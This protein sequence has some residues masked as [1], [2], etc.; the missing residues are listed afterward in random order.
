M[1]NF[2]Q[3]QN[4][5]RLETVGLIGVALCQGPGLVYPGNKRVAERRRQYYFNNKHNTLSP[6]QVY[7][8][9]HQ[10]AVDNEWDWVVYCHDDLTIHEPKWTYNLRHLIDL[11]DTVAVGLGGATG[12]GHPNL[13]K[14][15]YRMDLM[16]RSNYMSNQTDAETHGKR[17]NDYHQ[18]AVLDAFCM[19]VKTSFIEHVGG[20]PTANL[21]HHCL[22]L[23]L[24]CEAARHNQRIYMT[25][26]SCTHHGGGTS[27]K[28]VYNKA[29][30]LKY[31]STQ[32]DHTEPHAWLYDQYPDVLPIMIDPKE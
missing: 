10:Y 30:W 24:A 18:V 15:P 7:Q 29:K 3:Y 27:T 17:T 25:P 21:T 31:G 26:V 23:W 22:D 6:C 11:D 5:D 32:D 2:I 28:A 16:A 20:W 1:K 9:I 14:V 12:L 13:Y 4:T 8:N 19:A